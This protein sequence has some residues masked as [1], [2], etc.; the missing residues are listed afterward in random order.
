MDR[1]L[2][3]A[4]VLLLAAPTGAPADVRHGEALHGSNCVA[5]H[6]SGMYTRPDRRIHSYEALVVQVNRCETSLGLRWFP[7]DVSAVAEFLNQR[8][9]RFPH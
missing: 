8:Y 5:C 9:Y 1:L 2:L 4:L 3:G 6:D 7:K